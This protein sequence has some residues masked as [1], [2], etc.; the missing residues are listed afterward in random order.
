MV[1]AALAAALS[2][3]QLL[4]AQHTDSAIFTLASLVFFIQL[5]LHMQTH[6]YMHVISVRVVCD[7]VPWQHA[8]LHQGIPDKAVPYIELEGAY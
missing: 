2:A 8:D 7:G 5:H 1:I 6:K 4:K 3:A